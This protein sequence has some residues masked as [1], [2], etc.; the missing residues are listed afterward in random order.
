MLGHRT[1]VSVRARRLLLVL[2]AL[3]LTCALGASLAGRADAAYGDGFGLA[4]AEGPALPGP[5]SFWAGACEI[6]A[7]PGIGA[8]I[9]DGVGA[10]PDPILVH[11]TQASRWVNPSGPFEFAPI[12]VPAPPGPTHCVDAGTPA[13]GVPAW[14]DNPLG[15]PVEHA[16]SW[17]LAPSTAAGAH[18]DGSAT[19]TYAREPGAVNI[20][21][22]PDN[23][24]VD[25]PAGFVGNPTAVAKCSAEQFAAVPVECPPESQV[26]IANIT[27]RNPVTGTLN[28]LLYPVY[29]LEARAGKTAELGIPDVSGSTSA[30][31]VAEAR[32]NGDFGVRT[33]VPQ[34]PAALDLYGQTITLW[35]VP[36]AASHDIW[37]IRQGVF[38]GGVIPVTMPHSGLPSGD[39]APYEASWGP[40]KPF[41]SNPVECAGAEL[42]TNLATDSYQDP[43]SFTLDGDPDLTDLDWKTYSAGAPAVTDCDVPEFQPD[44]ALSP[45]SRKADS[46][47]GLDVELSIPQN[48]EP[49][50]AVPG[51]PNLATD[52]DDADGAPAYWRSEEGRATAQ[53]DK[54][55]VALPEGVSVN[56][57]GATGLAGCSDAQVGLT[58]P[59]SPPLFNDEDPF[60]G[61]GQECPAG[62]RIGT[63]EVQTPLLEERLEGVVVL[64]QPK[65]TNPASGEM[66]RLFLVL[67]SEQRGLLAKVY[68][69]AVADPATGRLTATFDNNPR[70]PFE[71]MSLRF[72]GGARA[73]LAQPQRCGSPTWASTLTPWTAAHGAGGLA[74]PDGG[75]FEVDSGCLLSFAPTLAAGMSNPKGRA[76]GAFSFQ[77]TRKDG[78]R[79]LRGLTAKLPT[80]LLASVRGVP[81]CASAQAAAGLCPRGSKIGIVDA[82]AG[83]GDPFVLEQKGEVF[84]TEGYKGGEY[85]LAVKIRPIAGPFRGAMELSPIV[86]RQ[87]IHV[88]RRTA[89]VTA[90][91][92]PF[93]L[94]HHGIPLRVREVLVNVDRP[95]FMLNPS[96]CSAKRIEA[97]I[98]SPEGA[99]AEVADRFQAA[100]CAALPFKP[101]L[102]LRLTGR[103]QVKTGAHPGVR[104]QVNQ[105][106]VDEAG[107]KRAQ[108]RLPKSLALDPDNAQALCEFADGTKDDIERHCP[109][110]SIV[111]R[112]RAVSPLLNDP[113]V[114]NVY[115]VKNVRRS[116]T[117]NLI[118]TLPMIVVALRGE[119]AVNLRGVSSTTKSGRLV[120]TFDDVPDAPISQFN[121]N[122]KGGGNGILTVTRT[123]KARINL[124]NGRHVANADIDGQNGRRHDINV[125]MNTR[126]KRRARAN[127]RGR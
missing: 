117:G 77:F 11:P 16:P 53:L 90:I 29:N 60:D 111:G 67:E 48:D 62:S 4:A 110:G 12:L 97:T 44:I 84:L 8:S 69:T 66:I 52:P 2:A 61:D 45:T 118:R 103:R 10:R 71:Q 55:V 96:D 92:D 47:T 107:I 58:Q 68:G 23:I 41:V 113:L 1:D 49:P 101:R 5:H 105:A 79:Y 38:T 26:G 42:S 122:I 28:S 106:G 34:I 82:A 87:A 102:S 116:S 100:G 73:Q 127:R 13:Q 30:R 123:R 20:N 46:P 19:F 114:G 33:Y 80:G 40:I 125:R 126:C 35:G 27:L 99:R 78:E 112:A 25:L 17:R 75:S 74:T 108:V 98:S 32:T 64:G 70:V 50:Q 51:N 14:V 104:A 21:G 18:P 89:Q 93:P 36:W 120:N 81:L 6:G 121:L 56:P 72:K 43:G 39:R 115:F 76:T 22:A 94:I 63:V 24:V 65:S 91:S 15:G 85:G 57:S 119:I 7:A 3:L 59:G 109:K 95:R 88:D 124:C 83:A 86:V 9:P 37:R 31:V 54:A